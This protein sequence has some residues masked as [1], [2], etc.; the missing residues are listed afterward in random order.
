MCVPRVR[1]IIAIMETV[2]RVHLAIRIQN[3]MQR[4][5]NAAIVRIGIIHIME[6]VVLVRAIFQYFLSLQRVLESV[7]D[8]LVLFIA[9]VSGTGLHTDIVMVVLVS[10]V[11]V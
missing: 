7:I 10:A 3:I 2:L 8:V 1:P 11:A 6:H 4:A 9:V 5:R